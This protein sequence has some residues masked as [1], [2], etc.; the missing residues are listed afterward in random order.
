M[1]DPLDQ[2]DW[3]TRSCLMGAINYTFAKAQHPIVTLLNLNVFHHT[4]QP[5]SLF[6]IER[7]F[8]GSLRAERLCNNWVTPTQERSQF[9]IFISAKEEAFSEAWIK[10]GNR[11]L[12]H[13]NQ[14]AWVL[15]L[16]GIEV[17]TK[18]NTHFWTNLIP[19][20][21]ITLSLISKHCNLGIWKRAALR[22][23]ASS[24]PKWLPLQHDPNHESTDL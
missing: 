12:E 13:F 20:S 15:Q 9:S 2:T 4:N 22:S 17:A 6:A 18:L 23:S 1:L 10:Y 16:I 5:S 19:S 8:N 7:L 21:P 11:H 14:C 3:I 24:F